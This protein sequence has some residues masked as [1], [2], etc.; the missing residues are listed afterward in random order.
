MG[1]VDLKTHYKMEDQANATQL[2]TQMG[3]AL[4]VLQ[5]VGAETVMLT[6]NVLDALTSGRLVS[7]DQIPL[8]FKILT[9]T[10]Y[11]NPFNPY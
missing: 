11:K 7:G 6:A 10:R 1:G 4:A 2:L 9:L 8:P 5:V 3:G